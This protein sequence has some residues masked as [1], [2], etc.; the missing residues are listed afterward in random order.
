VVNCPDIKSADCERNNLGDIVKRKHCELIKKWADGAAIQF[1]HEGDHVWFDLEHPT[2]NDGCDYRV[3]PEIKE[4]RLAKMR[5]ES[6][7][8]CINLYFDRENEKAVERKPIFVKWLTDW[9]EVE[10]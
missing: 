9:Q 6:G 3:K 2:W 4:F 10:V 7:S 5:A 8:E 1:C